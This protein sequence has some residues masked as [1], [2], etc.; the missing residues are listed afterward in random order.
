MRELD[1]LTSSAFRK[2]LSGP[3]IVL[4]NYFGLAATK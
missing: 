1:I 4:T 3:D 2:R